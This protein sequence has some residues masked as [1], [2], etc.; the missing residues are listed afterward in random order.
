MDLIVGKEL[1]IKLLHAKLTVFEEHPILTQEHPSIEWWES[2]IND[3]ISF[4]GLLNMFKPKYK[5]RFLKDLFNHMDSTYSEI[6]N[7]ILYCWNHIHSF[8]Y[9]VYFSQEMFLRFI[10]NADCKK[11]MTEKELSVFSSF[12]DSLL[13]YRGGNNSTKKGMCWT[14]DKEIAAKY[15]T[16]YQAIIPK[17]YIFAYKE[18][19][20]TVILH[21]RRLEQLKKL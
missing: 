3:C 6:G 15:G 1:A 12:T 10:I 13:V 4:E 11:W 5:F 16:V 20:Q 8:K 14:L 21:Y 18:Q 9:N 2:K 7:L 19:D 17:K